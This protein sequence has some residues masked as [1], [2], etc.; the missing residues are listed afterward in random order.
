ML[1]DLS[2]QKT[3]S[4]PATRR[5]VENQTLARDRFQS[6]LSQVD[7]KIFETATVP[8]SRYAT[9]YG[10]NIH[11]IE[12]LLAHI[13][14]HEMNQSLTADGTHMT[15]EEF[16]RHMAIEAEAEL[17]LADQEDT[18]LGYMAKLVAL[19]SMALSEEAMDAEQ[20][21]SPFPANNNLA[22]AVPF[23]MSN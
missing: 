23:F 9:K 1:A 3:A 21:D 18:I 16:I 22:Q 17:A 6:S 8:E 10:Q 5:L 14:T 15:K 19:D 12:K 11:A 20:A 13:Q 4:T 7:L 2:S